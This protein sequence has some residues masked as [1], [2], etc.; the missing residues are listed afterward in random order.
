MAATKSTT[1]SPFKA[2]KEHHG[3]CLRTAFKRQLQ[4]PVQT[5]LTWLGIS[6]ALS[7]PALILLAEQQTSVIRSAINHDPA[8]NVY[9]SASATTAQIAAIEKTVKNIMPSATTKLIDS[10][11]ALEQLKTSSSLD[12]VLNNLTTNPLP[13]TLIVSGNSEHFPQLKQNIQS[14]TAVEEVSF[15]QQWIQRWQWISHLS[16]MLSIS[17][18]IVVILGATITIVSTTSFQ[19]IHRQHEIEVMR[20]VGG[21]EEFIRRPFLYQG[22]ITGLCSGLM[23]TLWLIVNTILAYTP[24]QNLLH[25]YHLDSVNIPIIIWFIPAIFGAVIGWGGARIA[26]NRVLQ[27]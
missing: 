16:E 17:I 3:N 9:I 26:C 6:I 1:R 14:L 7:L 20:L 23:A 4:T 27:R 12:G 22:T 19:I 11:A 13:N 2:W 18:T 24:W 8:L 25:S 10:K 5:F 21:T 15:D